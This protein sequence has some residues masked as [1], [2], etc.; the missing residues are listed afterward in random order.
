MIGHPPLLRMRLARQVPLSIWIDFERWNR[1]AKDWQRWMPDCPQIVVERKDHVKQLD[2]RFV[3]GMSV[4]CFAEEWSGRFGDLVDAVI[5]Q[6]PRH[7]I[8]HAFD[9]ETPLLWPQ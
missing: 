2:L 7:L 4:T 3:V 6:R 1:F 5:A 8:A 9:L